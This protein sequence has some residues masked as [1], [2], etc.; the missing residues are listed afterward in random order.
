MKG[1]LP[2][3]CLAACLC[4][5]IPYM[6]SGRYE[7]TDYSFVII[8]LPRNQPVQMDILFTIWCYEETQI[9][10]EYFWIPFWSFLAAHGHIISASS[11]L[12]RHL[13]LSEPCYYQVCHAVFIDLALRTTK[14]PW[15][16]NTYM[17]LS[18][19]LLSNPYFGWRFV[20][21]WAPSHYT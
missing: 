1:S 2:D 9:Y 10:I 4:F 17:R 14:L 18:T 11:W 19:E 6:L 13:L 3:I 21:Y 7:M 8:R 20:D 16:S 12:T 15:P 5:L